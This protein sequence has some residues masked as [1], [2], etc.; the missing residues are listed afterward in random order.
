MRGNKDDVLRCLTE[1]YSVLDGVPP[2]GPYRY[3]D[4]ST[5]NGYNVADYGGYSDNSMGNNQQNFRANNAAGYVNNPYVKKSISSYLFLYLKFSYIP[6]PPPPPPPQ[7]YPPYGGPYPDDNYGGNRNRASG[8]NHPL[9]QQ[10]GPVTTTQVTIP[11][12]M[13]GKIFDISFIYL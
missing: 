9:Y 2:R 11:T 7:G 1:V 6:P 3:Y 12:E 4:P 8:Y 10:S 13:A 5:Y